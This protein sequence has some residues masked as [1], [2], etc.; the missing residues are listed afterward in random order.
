MSICL[1]LDYIYTLIFVTLNVLTYVCQYFDDWTLNFYVGIC[2]LCVR[3]LKHMFIIMGRNGEFLEPFLRSVA[4]SFICEGESPRPMC[5]LKWWFLTL[6]M[7]TCVYA[8]EGAFSSCIYIHVFIYFYMKWLIASLV[9]ISLISSLVILITIDFDAEL[10]SR[11]R[12]RKNQSLSITRS[13]IE[14]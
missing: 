3:S 10:D 12:L 6:L 1:S 5:F 8:R 9:A 7:D 2:Y 4:M 13:I 14:T 11:V